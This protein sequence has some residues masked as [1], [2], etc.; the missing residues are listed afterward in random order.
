MGFLSGSDGKEAAYNVGDL[1][2][3]PRSGRTTGE[4]SDYPLQYSCLEDSRDREV[5]QATVY[6]VKKSQ[7]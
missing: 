7:T 4:E 2:L 6:R 3:I 5:S 1:G